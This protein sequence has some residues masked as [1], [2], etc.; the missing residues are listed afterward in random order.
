M[1]WLRDHFYNFVY[2][3]FLV[4][5][6]NPE[7]SSDEVPEHGP[8]D[9]RPLPGEVLDPGLPSEL[10]KLKILCQRHS[11]PWNTNRQT[12]ASYL[13]GELHYD[14]LRRSLL[15]AEAQ[16]KI[17]KCS[18]LLFAG[19][20]VWTLEV[21]AQRR[22]IASVYIPEMSRLV[23]DHYS[24]S[25][26][27][28]IFSLLTKYGV[29]PSESFLMVDTGFVGSIV[30]AISRVI[31]RPIKFALMSQNPQRVSETELPPLNSFSG[32]TYFRGKQPFNANTLP[33]Q[34]FPNRRRAREEV[35]GVEYLPKYFKT[36]TIRED[37]VV[38]YLSSPVDI[39]GAA[40]LTSDLWRGV[41][42]RKNQKNQKE[43]VMHEP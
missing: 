29:N 31:K 25:R 18:R 12:M 22:K 33:N 21:L 2:P 39:V 20:D 40:V 37:R 8:C 35:L 9:V 28:C 30:R 41:K 32:N 5:V 3:A 10:A 19:R 36:G 38:Q 14:V 1:S 16:R 11:V 6:E 34:L 42:H 7:A 26:D 23:V 13:R 43:E 15:S 24:P 4:A 27:Q 17:H